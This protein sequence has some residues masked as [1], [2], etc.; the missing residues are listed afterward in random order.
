[1]R[2]LDSE[3]I[4]CLLNKYMDNIPETASEEAKVAYIK[5]LLFIVLEADENTSAP[6]AVELVMKAREEI[7]GLRDD[8]TKEKTYYNEKMLS[9]ESE[10]SRI[11]NTSP[12]PFYT[13]VGFSFAGN[14]IDFGTVQGV[15]EDKLMEILEKAS[16]FEFSVRELENLRRDCLA[17]K[18][19]VFLLDNCGE[20]VMDKILMKIIKKMNDAAEITAIVRGAPVLNDCTLEDAKQVN[21]DSL[22]K[23]IDNGT[24]IAGTCLERIT[25]EAR[26]AIEEAD[27]IISKGQGNFETLSGSGRNVYYLF[28]CKCHK[29]SVR[30]GV[31][32]MSAMLL[33]DKRF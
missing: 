30:F 15:Q 9:M 20:I 24:A 33:N 12:D 27:V 22:A 17:A 6:E 25:D 8:Y 4:R 14:Y 13:A 29:F 3:C 21:I 16:R 2:L 11:V 31:P 1:M 5:R 23:V 10:I 26:Q 19:I 7:F 28:L 18:R 32:G